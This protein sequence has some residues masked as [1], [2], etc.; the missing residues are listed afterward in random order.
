MLQRNKS[1]KHKL[2]EMV[3]EKYILAVSLL[4]FFIS[5]GCIMMGMIGYHNLDLAQNM[6]FLNAKYNMTFIDH[7]SND[8]YMDAETGYILGSKQLLYS[9]YLLAF[10]SLSALADLIFAI[11]ISRFLKRK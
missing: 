7:A 9:F 8:A 11:R 2:I 6:R 5:I 1:G 10:I 4:L 3:R